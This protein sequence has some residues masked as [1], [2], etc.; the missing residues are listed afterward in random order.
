MLPGMNPKQMQKAMKQLGIRQEE[1][2]AIAVII[3]TKS[4]DI[5]ITNPS[6][7]KVN[8][9]GQISYQI[10]GEEEHRAIEEEIEISEEDIKTVMEQANISSEK[11]KIA[12]EEHKGDLAAAILSFQK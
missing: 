5:I 4:E 9:S 10:S 6:I 11:A 1:I 12:L 2:E 3:R 7:Q 8:M